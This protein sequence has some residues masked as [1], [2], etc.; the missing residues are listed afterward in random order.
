MPEARDLM[1]EGILVESYCWDGA[2]HGPGSRLHR[3]W[4]AAYYHSLK[5]GDLS[6]GVLFLKEL[7]HWIVSCRCTMHIA[8]GALKRALQGL[9]EDKV[10]LKSAWVV[11]ASLRSSIGQLGR[12]A[13]SW[14]N[15]RVGFVEWSMPLEHQEHLWRLLGLPTEVIDYLLRFGLR[16]D[17]ARQQ[18]LVSPAH[19][20][21]KTLTE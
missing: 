3:Q 19:V 5:G 15:Q 20:S 14:V 8:H 2:L 6:Q 1:P 16:W 12:V 4:H 13:S 9:A 21:S 17:V 10:C 7:T 11:L 18:L